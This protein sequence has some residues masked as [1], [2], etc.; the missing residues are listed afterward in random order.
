MTHIAICDDEGSQ[1]IYLSALVRKWSDARGVAVRISDYD[2]AERFLFSYE[3]DKSASILLLDIQMKSMDGVA[4]ARKIRQDNDS[5]QIIFITGYSDYMAEGYDVSA[6]HYLMKPLKE[7]KLFEV[8]DRAVKIN[9]KKGKTIY[10]S[11]DGENIRVPTDE[12]QYIEAFDH[13]LEI[14]STKA[15][16]RV[17]MP[18]YE[19]EK[20][21]TDDFIR[22]HRGCIVNL[23]R[24]KKIT[25]TELTLDS[26]KVLPLSRRLYTEV[27][28]AMLKYISGGAK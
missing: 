24:V 23:E 22:C 9:S 28:R 4:L 5:V 21:L 10:L 2:S 18:L 20:Q 8:L 16:H 13:L 26:G 1:I 25:R 27:N 17:K 19:L 14:T 11:I 6:L 3:E 15:K 12:V 7:E